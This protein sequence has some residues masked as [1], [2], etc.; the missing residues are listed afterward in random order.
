MY[1]GGLCPDCSFSYSDTE[2]VDDPLAAGGKAV[3]IGAAAVGEMQHCIAFSEELFAKDVGAMIGIRIHARV[4]KNDDAKGSAFSVGTCDTVAFKKRDIRNFHVDI[5]DI[6]GGYQWYEID[7]TWK[8][9]GNEVLW[10][11]NGKRVNGVNPCIKAVYI[12]QIELY[13]KNLW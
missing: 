8:P 12:D 3:R 6:K 9:A 5:E 13:R 7:G 4:E 1:A 10:I 2:R 11:S